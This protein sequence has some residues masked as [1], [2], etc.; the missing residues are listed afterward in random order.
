[1]SVRMFELSSILSEINNV[2]QTEMQSFRVAFRCLN[3][4]TIPINGLSRALLSSKPSHA[5]VSPEKQL[6]S[7][8]LTRF[9]EDEVMLRDTGEL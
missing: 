9:H 3:R 4:T 2:S 7:P 6:F 5:S 8:P 1:M